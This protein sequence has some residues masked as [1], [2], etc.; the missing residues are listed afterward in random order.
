MRAHRAATHLDATQC[1][2]ARRDPPQPSATRHGA[3]RRG[4]RQHN[5]VCNSPNQ[6]RAMPS[7]PPKIPRDPLTHAAHPTWRG[8]ESHAPLSPSGAVWCSPDHPGHLLRVGAVPTL[9]GWSIARGWV[10]L[11]RWDPA[12]S[13]CGGPRD[14]HGVGL[15]PSSQHQRHQ[16][17]QRGAQAGTATWAMMTARSNPLAPPQT[18][19]NHLLCLFQE[20]PDSG[21]LHR[22][23]DEP[24]STGTCPPPSLSPPPRACGQPQPWRRPTR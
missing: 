2:T 18:P 3:T 8:W 4:A 16:C 13:P 9:G 21:H 7:P 10:G 1:N 11:C 15:P 5:P 12:P 17:H 24:G 14:S 23:Q 6:P 22:L 19:L 20:Q